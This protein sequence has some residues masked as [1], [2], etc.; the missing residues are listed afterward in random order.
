MADLSVKE[1]L[2][3][4][5]RGD[6]QGTF[7]LH[8]YYCSVDQ[9]RQCVYITTNTR[10]STGR[11]ACVVHGASH[12]RRADVFSVGGVRHRQDRPEWPS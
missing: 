6:H 10:P 4:P 3:M 8:A 2:D 1:L 12:M 11:S 5:E 7:E 9:P